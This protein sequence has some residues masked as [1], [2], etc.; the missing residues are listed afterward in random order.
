[1]SGPAAAHETQGTEKA[2]VNHM[3]APAEPDPAN[4]A[5]EAFDAFH[6][7]HEQEGE[8]DQAQYEQDRVRDPLRRTGTNG[9]LSKE[10]R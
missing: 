7:E 9:D 2:A 10:G 4:D 8:I 3:P 5:Q 1:M 6:H